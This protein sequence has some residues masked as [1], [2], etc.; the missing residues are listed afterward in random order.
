[1][2]ETIKVFI[3]SPSDVEYERKRAKEIV[4]NLKIEFGEDV[5]FD[6]YLY[7]EHH[8]TANRGDFQKQINRYLQEADIVIFIVWSRLGSK[9]SSYVGPV[10]GKK[11]VTGTEYEFEMALDL[12]QKTG[13]PDI[14]VYRKTKEV[15]LPPQYDSHEHRQKKKAL[16][17]VN[18]FFQTWFKN[19][20]NSIERAYFE[21]EDDDTL[22]AYLHS[23]IASIVREKRYAD[24]KIVHPY[25]G[26]NSFD[27]EDRVVF[28]GRDDDVRTFFERWQEE[29]APFVTVFG[30]SG[31]G[32][33]SFVK[34][35]L[36]PHMLKEAHGRFVVMR[37]LE[38]SQNPFETLAKKL[39]DIY[40]RQFEALSYSEEEL[41]QRLESSD[42]LPLRQVFKSDKVYLVFDQFEEIINVA[43]ALQERFFKF[44]Q[45]CTEELDVVVLASIRTNS[46]EYLDEKPFFRAIKRFD[47]HLTF[48]SSANMIQI[49]KKP[50][51]LA[52]LE[53]DIDPET[54][55]SLDKIIAEEA[56]KDPNALPLVE[57]TLTQ[58][59]ERKSCKE[60]KEGRCRLTIDA[61]KKIGELHGAVGTLAQQT[62][63]RL[64][65]KEKKIFE[66]LLPNLVTIK[67]NQLILTDYLPLQE[68]KDIVASFVEARLFVQK[69]E[70]IRVAHEAFFKYWDFAKKV[71]EETKSDMIQR[72]RI[73]ETYRLYEEQKSDTTA[74][75]QGSLLFIAE[76]IL[77][78]RGKEF[79]DKSIEGVSGYIQKSIDHAKK[80][81]RRKR[82]FLIGISATFIAL[83]GG[84]VYEYLEAEEKRQKMRNNLGLFYAERALAL[85]KEKNLSLSHLYVYY[86]LKY[87][88]FLESK[89][90]VSSMTGI[91]QCYPYTKLLHRDYLHR[92]GVY[93]AALSPDEKYIISVGDDNALIAREAVSPDKFFI[94]DKEHT[95]A[96]YDF[97]F[98]NDTTFVTASRDGTA[99]EWSYPDFRS[100][101]L[102]R[103]EF[104][105]KRIAYSK[106][107]TLLIF[108]SDEGRVVYAKY[109]SKEFHTVTYTTHS[110]KSLSI[111]DIAD[112]LYISF[113]RLSTIF[114][115]DLN[116]LQIKRKIDIEVLSFENYAMH[117]AK[118]ND[119]LFIGTAKGDLFEYC[120]KKQ[121]I[122]Q[123]YKTGTESIVTKFFKS[124]NWLYV[125][126][127]KGIFEIFHNHQLVEK[128]N[129]SF[130]TV[131]SL[132]TDKN[133]SILIGTSWDNACTI[134]DLTSRDRRMV[135]PGHHSAIYCVAP[136]GNDRVLT[137]AGLG[138]TD[139]RLWD[140][141][142]NKV[143]MEYLGHTGSI[144]QILVCSSGKRFIT[145]SSDTTIKI[146]DISKKECIQTLQKH[147]AE[148]FSLALS[149]DEKLLI[150]ASYDRSVIVW[151]KNEKGNFVYHKRYR[152]IHSDT[153]YGIAMSKDDAYVAT[154]SYDKT[155]KL[156]NIKRKGCPDIDVKYPKR[157]QCHSILPQVHTQRIYHL[158]FHP[159]NRFLFSCGRDGKIVRWEVKSG[160]CSS[161]KVFQDNPH[162]DR[163]YWLSLSPSGSKLASSS[164][165][166]TVRIWDTDG[167]CLSVLKG[168][169]KRIY[170]V[171]FIDEHTLASV[172]WDKTMR[173]WDIS[174]LKE[175]KMLKI[176]KRFPDADIVS[177]SKKIV[178]LADGTLLN[179]KAI[180]TKIKALESE[181]QKVLEGKQEMQQKHPKILRQ[182]PK[183]HPF[184]L[185]YKT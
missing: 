159:N 130:Q 49:I 134:Y 3:S 161:Y 14:F 85:L 78:R 42:I 25:K 109:P 170:C 126:F 34:A 124:S 156:W 65:E 142:A 82:N 28:F 31:C 166:K 69:G 2:V 169:Q 23:H 143:Q 138:G 100:K 89:E 70:Y 168:H 55:K 173:I 16:E 39:F 139:I 4:E 93:N 66:R 94:Y 121:A 137:G 148:V 158:L 97:V 183:E 38:A 95:D 6:V 105:L 29:K 172:S 50:A 146:W 104:K 84:A 30:T 114:V 119:S 47:Y 62:F 75:L 101:E 184:Y 33:S 77:K 86:A 96:I 122:T 13:K 27:F 136:V 64:N 117:I 144:R 24:S 131:E 181:C 129:S 10:S 147:Q 127:G 40:A 58:L 61:Y 56:M 20:Y 132:S 153:I 98:L 141:H 12:W 102:L 68:E 149:N 112:E 91:L 123:Y 152:N 157:K 163:V 185:K 71:I 120:E 53:F 133:A 41:Q 36:L 99:R 154:S 67:E 59:E 92:S 9:M 108:G 116:T 76:E 54:G 182:W 176:Y 178:R 174:N 43:D 125:P 175:P 35:G 118:K 32:K 164:K 1:M 74:L 160:R 51:E 11:G 81:D 155:I 7:E 180:E 115:I 37:P 88:D 80:I 44:L 107:H 103:F 17:E 162:K 111:D 135:I 165:D 18:A 90:I 151:K 63:E 26:L 52:H 73:A 145:A 113:S 167:K 60:V 110:V 106:K 21:F 8:Q 48:P 22:K 140:L 57:F 19:E 171:E 87:L 83:A 128:N 15:A 45:R 5:V 46:L 79:F 72:E 177:A 179:P 150:S